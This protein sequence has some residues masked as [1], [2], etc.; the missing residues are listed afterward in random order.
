MNFKLYM[1]SPIK[2]KSSKSTFLYWYAY[3]TFLLFE[4]I[5]RCTN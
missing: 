4:N 1:K 3:H 5:V 2:S